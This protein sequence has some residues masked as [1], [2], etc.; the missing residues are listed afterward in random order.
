M[1]AKRQRSSVAESER[2]LIDAQR[3]LVHLETRKAELQI[4]LYSAKLRNVTMKG[5]LLQRKL[6]E[7][8]Y[9]IEDVLLNAVAMT[10]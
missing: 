7:K 1:G 4:Q 8:G 10:D 6:I 9:A 2:L 3:D 5:T